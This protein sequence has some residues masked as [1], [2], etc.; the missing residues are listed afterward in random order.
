MLERDLVGVLERAQLDRL[1]GRALEEDEDR[2]L[3]P[4]VNDD[5]AAVVDLGHPRLS[6]VEEVDRLPHD[7]QRVAIGN[8]QL[9]APLPELFDLCLQVSH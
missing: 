9:A 1:H 6:G 2:L 3:E 5:V 4:L 7:R 8:G